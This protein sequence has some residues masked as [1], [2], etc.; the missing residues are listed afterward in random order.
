[1]IQAV[2]RTWNYQHKY[3]Y[4]G[5][6]DGPIALCFVHCKN[7]DKVGIPIKISLKPYDFTPCLPYS[8]VGLFGKKT[9]ILTW[10]E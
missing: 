6:V 5:S 8:I 10:T 2:R 1:M 4:L 9:Q 7:R 3:M